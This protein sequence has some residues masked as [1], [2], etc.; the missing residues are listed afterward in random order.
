MNSN[1]NVRPLARADYEQW[2]PLWAGYNEFY[3]RVGPTA[4]ATEITAATWSRFFDAYEPLHA[5]VAEH[6][7]RVVGLVHYLYHRDTISIAPLC[8]L[9]DL[10]T[11]ASVRGR[12]VARALIE[13]VYQAARDAGIGQVYWLTH[14]TNTTAR[15]LYDKVADRPGFIVYGKNV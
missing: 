3:G 7:G 11:D 13:A 14:E 2:L 4:L 12:G 1:V 15:T 5:L 10:F 8:Y 6:E 9:A